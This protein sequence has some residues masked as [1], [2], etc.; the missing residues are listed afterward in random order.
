MYVCVCVVLSLLM[1]V[2]E[3]V[4]SLIVKTLLCLVTTLAIKNFCAVGWHPSLETSVP[5]IFIRP[6]KNVGAVSVCFQ[7]F[8]ATK[9]F[10]CDPLCAVFFTFS[11]VTFG[12]SLCFYEL[13]CNINGM[14]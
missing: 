14:S 8:T 12:V 13:L 10:A 1:D 11:S 3:S 5:N 6:L 9:P 7:S 2:S 4:T